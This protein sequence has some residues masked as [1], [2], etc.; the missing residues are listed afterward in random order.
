[1]TL[2]I[3]PLPAACLKHGPLDRQAHQLPHDRSWVSPSTAPGALVSENQAPHMPWGMT[4]VSN[5]PCA[6]CRQL[7]G[8]SES[9]VHGPAAIIDWFIDCY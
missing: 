6:T 5:V 1:M 2:F 4:T 7:A 8:S 3:A 9:T